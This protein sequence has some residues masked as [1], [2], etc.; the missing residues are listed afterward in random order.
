MVHQQ[1]NVLFTS[2]TPSADSESNRSV[3]DAVITR[4]TRPTTDS[5]T[6]TSTTQTSIGAQTS[7]EQIVR[8]TIAS[9]TGK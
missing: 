6:Q 5:A 4:S 8:G 7:A 9:T 2:G 3:H 1:E